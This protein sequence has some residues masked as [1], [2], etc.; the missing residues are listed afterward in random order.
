MFFILAICALIIVGQVLEFSNERPAKQ[1]QPAARPI[2]PIPYVQKTDDGR[3]IVAGR[4]DPKTGK[5]MVP[6]PKGSIPPDY[7]L[8]RIE[9]RRVNPDGS[10]TTIGTVNPSELKR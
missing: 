5:V 7:A 4:V 2:A 8:E 1:A 3:V 6:I 9:L 10:Q